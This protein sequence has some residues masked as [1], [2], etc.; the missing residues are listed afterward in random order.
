LSVPIVSLPELSVCS[1]SG[2]Q[3]AAD[4]EATD[5]PD[6]F[7]VDSPQADATASSATRSGAITN[8]RIARS[9]HSRIRG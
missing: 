2:V 3:D 7:A 5:P 9:Y 6:E 1:F 4:A 8:L